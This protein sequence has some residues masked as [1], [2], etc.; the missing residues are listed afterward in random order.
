M[1]IKEEV[2]LAIDMGIESVLDF[3]FVSKMNYWFP[4][5][6]GYYALFNNELVFLSCLSSGRA[7]D[8]FS[9]DK[10]EFLKEN[11]LLA[12]EVWDQTTNAPYPKNYWTDELVKLR[13]D[14]K[15]QKRCQELWAARAGLDDKNSEYLM[16]LYDEATAE[17]IKI[18]RRLD[19]L[20]R[21]NEVEA[22]GGVMPKSRDF[23]IAALRT[24][25]ISDFV[26]VNRAGFFKVRD[27]KTPS[28]KYYKDENMWVD[29]GGD[30]QRHDVIDLICLLHKCNFRDACLFLEG[31]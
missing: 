25:P 22:A 20:K 1:N 26:E 7:I 11:P 16:L 2:Q 30:N 23:D 4:S 6:V 24:I 15:G 28:C 31:K 17:I 18:N 13:Y 21:R 14:L 29:F 5:D 12:K 3:V 8:G 10:R 27:E 9:Y 19:Y